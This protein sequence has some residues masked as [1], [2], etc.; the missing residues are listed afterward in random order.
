[1]RSQRYCGGFFYC[2]LDDDGSG[3]ASGKVAVVCGEA[4]ESRSG[5]DFVVEA[6]VPFDRGHANFELFALINFA[7]LEF[8]QLYVEPIYLGAETVYRSQKS[9]TCYLPVLDFWGW[10]SLAS[11]SAFKRAIFSRVARA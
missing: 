4:V 3:A 2:C 5:G 1:M 7:F 11:R 6:E 10:A 8:C 9:K